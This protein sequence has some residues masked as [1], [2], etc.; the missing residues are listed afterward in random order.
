[1]RRPCGGKVRRKRWK[2]RHWVGPPF[3]GLHDIESLRTPVITRGPDSF[4]RL[5]YG[6]GTFAERNAIQLHQFRVEEAR[7][8]CLALEICERKKESAAQR[9][10]QEDYN[11]R[12][13]EKR[14]LLICATGVSQEGRPCCRP[15]EGAE[16]DDRHS[17]RPKKMR[18][19]ILF[20]IK[21]HAYGGKSW[22]EPI[23]WMR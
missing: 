21:C 13:A 7:L 1:M 8:D 11:R 4:L 9:Q 6:A 16:A 23:R 20:F 2:R 15:A 3:L 5:Q 18:P 10:Q 22:I 12:R 17:E 19:D 14:E